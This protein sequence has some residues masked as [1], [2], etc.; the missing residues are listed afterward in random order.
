MS[1]W[2]TR[3]SSFLFVGQLNGIQFAFG[4]QVTVA[5]TG[6]LRF[7]GLQFCGLIGGGIRT[8]SDEQIALSDGLAFDSQQFR[9]DSAANGFDRIG[10][11]HRS[12]RELRRDFF[13]HRNGDG[14]NRSQHEYGQQ[15]PSQSA[16]S[17]MRR[18]QIQEVGFSINDKRGGVRNSGGHKFSP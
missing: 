5:G 4:V 18:R 10:S 1:R 14:G 13:G 2:R 3:L 8:Q 16:R 7:D 15:R 12:Q 11:A 9:D 6:Q 17:P